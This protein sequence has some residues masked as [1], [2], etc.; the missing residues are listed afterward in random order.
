MVHH[1]KSSPTPSPEVQLL[2]RTNTQELAKLHQSWLD[3]PEDL[4]VQHRTNSKEWH[5]P[6]VGGLYT[7]C[8]QKM[9]HRLS[10]GIRGETYEGDLCQDGCFSPFELGI[11]LKVN[12][13]AAERRAREELERDRKFY[14][15]TGV[16]R[17]RTPLWPVNPRD[18]ES[19]DS[20]WVD[21]ASLKPEPDPE[22]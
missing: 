2:G 17:P 20:A 21:P 15:G 22:K 6:A 19:Q 1:R 5:R 8:G 13:E 16:S 18:P 4:T 12:K 9:D 14:S 10:G 3:R 7:A 11:S